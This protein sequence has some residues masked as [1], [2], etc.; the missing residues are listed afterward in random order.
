MSDKK[1]V[2]RLLAKISVSFS[3]I[4]VP[5]PKR[6]KRAQWKIFNFS[7]HFQMF[8]V[9]IEVL[10]RCTGDE[11]KSYRRSG[12]KPLYLTKRRVLPASFSTF[13]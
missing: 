11:K 6:K 8:G 3:N 12:L 2:C 9:L 10:V 5:G 1:A 13:V 4:S 7:W